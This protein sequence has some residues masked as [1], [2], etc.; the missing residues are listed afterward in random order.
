MKE[1][2]RQDTLDSLLDSINM[3]DTMEKKIDDF[4]RNKERLKRIEPDRTPDSSRR[5]MAVHLKIRTA[6]KPVRTNRPAP[7]RRPIRNRK[8]SRTS[9]SLWAT[10]LHPRTVLPTTS[11]QAMPR[12]D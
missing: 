6:R 7:H 11:S 1:N 2:D 4:A 5:P 9:R 12:P 8:R 10:P 3:D